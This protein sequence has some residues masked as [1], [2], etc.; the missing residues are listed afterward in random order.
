MTTLFLWELELQAPL[1]ARLDPAVLRGQLEAMLRVDLNRHWGVE[2][3]S[4]AGAGMEYGVNPGGFLSAVSDYVR[5]TGDRAWAL[6]QENELRSFC[7]PGL[8]DYGSYEN[9]LEC[10]STYEHRIA[11]FNALNV[12]GMRFVAGLFGDDKLA[13]AADRLAREVVALYEDG[14][15]AC[16]QPDGERRVVRTILDFNY[17]GRCLT[18]DLPQAVRRGMVAFF[19]RELRTDNWLHALSPR[20]P[21]ALTRFLPTFQTFRADH[22]ATGSYDAWPARAASVLLRFGEHDLAREWLL[23]LQE[24]TGEGPFG[25]AHFIHDDGVRKASFFNGNC[26]FNAAPAAYA[27]MLLDDWP[28]RDMEGNGGRS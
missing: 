26:Y 12:A 15:F 23:A 9:V 1:V 14:P 4:G 5:V 28:A 7:R 11:S 21:N 27:A 10:V 17:A 8:T 19:E 25:Q 13:A 16:L 24:L 18:D 22:Q 6:A 20:D 3:V 2:S